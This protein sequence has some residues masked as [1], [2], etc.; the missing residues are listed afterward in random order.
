[1]HAKGLWTGW[2]RETRSRKDY[3]Q[4]EQRRFVKRD[5]SVVTDL[6]SPQVQCLIIRQIPN[7]DS[8]QWKNTSIAWVVI[9][10]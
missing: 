9:L 2:W 1:M 4:E 6:S 3:H 7:E 10:T 5:G 8:Q